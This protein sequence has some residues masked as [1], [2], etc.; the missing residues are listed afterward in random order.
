MFLWQRAEIQALSRTTLKGLP[1]SDAAD[2]FDRFVKAGHVPG[3]R[4][5]V[6]LSGFPSDCPREVAFFVGQLEFFPQQFGEQSRTWMP[7]ADAAFPR[8]R[9]SVPGRASIGFADRERKV[10]SLDRKHLGLNF[11]SLS[12]RFPRG[13][14]DQGL[15]TREDL[16]SK[17]LLVWQLQ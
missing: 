9:V 2:A 6:D 10:V 7:L 3:Y 14:F 15:T 1:L 13:A 5:R 12:Q 16:F 11:R 4:Q 17:A 8:P